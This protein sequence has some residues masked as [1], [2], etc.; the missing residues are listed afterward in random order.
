MNCWLNIYK[1]RGISSSQVVLMIKKL[2]KSLNLKVGHTG[3]LDLEAEGVLPIAIGEATK[4]AAFLIEAKKTYVFTV[5]FGA[6]TDTGDAAGKVSRLTHT[7]PKKEDIE[8]NCKKFVGNISQIPPA[9]SAIKVN[10]VRS[11]KLA[12]QGDHQILKSRN[13]TIYDFKMNNYDAQTHTA[14]FEA[15][16]SKGT[17]V[18]TLAEDLALSLQSLCFVIELKRTQVGIF[19]ERES[20]NV[21]ELE[22]MSKEIIPNFL[23]HK[24]VKIEA[25]LD[26]IL[27]LDANEDQ[28]KKIKSG[29]KCFFESSDNTKFVWIRYKNVLL[30][31]G[32]ISNNCFKS[33]RV[34]NLI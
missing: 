22:E 14:I 30:A 23:V 10:G 8:N 26:D 2:S 20:L 6:S 9:Y 11:Y 18:R 13:V 16:C 19:N 21:R 24:S 31:I 28:M 25:V 15:I 4:L 27:V 32:S 7:I 29:Q 1:P 17:Y 12:R 3:T 34:F 33:A 5:K